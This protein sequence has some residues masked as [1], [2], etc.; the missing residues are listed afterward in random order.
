[1]PVKLHHTSEGWYYQWG[2][3]GKKYFFDPD[4]PEEKTM[5]QNNVVRQGRAAFAH[6][7]HGK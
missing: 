3:H 5:A 4:K 1:M 6:G 2:E 7:Y